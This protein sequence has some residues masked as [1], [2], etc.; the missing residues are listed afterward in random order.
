MP[1]GNRIKSFIVL[2]QKA[3]HTD[4]R[5]MTVSSGLLSGYSISS[6]SFMQLP[7]S[8]LSDTEEKSFA[9]SGLTQAGYNWVFHG[10]ASGAWLTTPQLPF[11]SPRDPNFG[12]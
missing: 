3:T 8:M 10:P 11:T 5:M 1:V 9:Y 6:R 4:S 12:L 2:Q 7:Y